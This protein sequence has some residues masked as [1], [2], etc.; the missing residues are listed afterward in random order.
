MERLLNSAIGKYA[1]RHIL[2]SDKQ[3]GFKVVHNAHSAI[4]EKQEARLICLDISRA[5]D[6]VWHKGL[7]AKLESIGIQ[8]KLPSWL[9]E[10]LKNRVLKVAINGICSG[11]VPQGSI[12]GPFLL[13]IFINELPDKIQNHVILYADDTSVFST[14]K[15]KQ[16]RATV[17]CS[18]T[19]DL[20]HIKKWA[21]NWNVMFAEQNRTE[22]EEVEP[23]GYDLQEHGEIQDGICFICM[24]ESLRNIARQT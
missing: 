23:T 3:F 11:S 20:L 18:L 19:E 2:I 1:C 16:L 8:E 21:D 14:V 10:Y 6:R 4:D 13:I 5:F 12:L 9:N 15:D 7:M 22:A 17:A 24:D